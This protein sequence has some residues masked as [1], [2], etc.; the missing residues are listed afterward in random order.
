MNKFKCIVFDLDGTL[1][2]S[3]PLLFNLYKQFLKKYNC[4]GTK[5]EFE[6]LNGPKLDQII[7]YLKKKKV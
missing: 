7:T 3:T 5:K 2:D 1:I 4:V 6:L